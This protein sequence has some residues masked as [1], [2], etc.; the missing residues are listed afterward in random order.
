MRTYLYHIDFRPPSI[1]DEARS[2]AFIS[3]LDR[4]TDSRQ[5]ET[6]VK[7]NHFYSC[8]TISLQFLYLCPSSSYTVPNHDSN[9]QPQQNISPI[10]LPTSWVSTVILSESFCRQLP[11]LSESSLRKPRPKPRPGPGARPRA[12]PAPPPRTNVRTPSFDWPPKPPLGLHG[13]LCPTDEEGGTTTTV[14]SL[15]SQSE[16]L[17]F[18]SKWQLLVTRSVP[19]S[20]IRVT[21]YLHIT[22]HRG[23]DGGIA[24]RPCSQWGSRRWDSSGEYQRASNHFSLRTS[25]CTAV[26]S[27]THG[28]SWPWSAEPAIRTTTGTGIDILL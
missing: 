25:S 16:S 26:I 17:I 8:T 28:P 22:W 15:S 12:P 1:I 3:F 18:P 10:I 19:R 6:R 27:R 7:S 4:Q 11:D 2:Y 13:G 9:N 5:T 23:A 21:G 20:Q 14:S 24:R